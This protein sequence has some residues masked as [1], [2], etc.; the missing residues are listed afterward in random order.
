MRNNLEA[1]EI[2]HYIH[3]Y[4]AS[5][6]LLSK[7]VSEHTIK[8]Y[9]DTLT[10]YLDFLEIKRNITVHTITY[11]NFNGNT[12]DDWIEWLMCERKCLPQSV[13]VR[14]C[15][16]RAFLN[17]L[18]RKD[19]SLNY[20]SLEA[21]KIKKRKTQKNKVH[22]LSKEAVKAL[23]K[24]I[25]QSTKTGRRDMAMFS[26]F[27][28]TATRIDEILSLKIKDIHLDVKKPF[29]TITGKGNKF[30]SLYLKKKTIAHIQKCI[31]EYHGYDTDENNYL[32][33]SIIKGKNIKMTQPA[34][35][36]QLKKWA[37]E[38]NKV[39]KDVPLDL[40]PHQIR[41]TV[42]THWLEDGMNVGEIQYLLGHESIQT[43]MIYL[44]ITVAQEALAMSELMS[45]DE[46][47]Q[48]KKWK[49]DIQKLRDL[50]K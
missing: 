11:E 29:I 31:Q 33:Y 48:P 7:T 14:L 1:Y 8:S 9:K 40:H 15:S 37:K 12:I 26:L 50:C 30:R 4:L 20:L 49:K 3:E 13:N 18:G 39:C 46:K 19:I 23:G 22:G 32:F 47:A 45:D 35:S 16:L 2:A 24:T 41:H 5:Y 27:Y 28:D 10:L 44:E 36:K 17:Y 42:A 34:V 21:D 38:A 6:C 43:T 25:N